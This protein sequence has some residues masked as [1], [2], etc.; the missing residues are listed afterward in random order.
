MMRMSEGDGG[1][2]SRWARRKR[3]AREVRA[4]EEAPA[5]EP[6]AEAAPAACDEAPAPA[7]EAL[8]EA[9]LPP[10]ESLGAQSD[11]T[12]FLKAGVPKALRNAALR[13]AWASDPAIT[14]HKPLVDYDWDFNAPGYGKLWPSD[15]PKKMVEALFRHLR[16]EPEPPAEADAQPPASG[17]DPAP[18]EAAPVE[19]ESVEPGPGEPEPAEPALAAEP[20]PPRI[21][22]ARPEAPAEPPPVEPDARPPEPPRPRRRHGGAMP[23]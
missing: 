14:G 5:E 23:S 1:F 16:K 4:P 15:N 21:A 3:E 6:A 7:E 18:E 11:Y 10:I 17:P 22:Q 13:K 20:A 8:D 2:L 12:V 9:A 19:P